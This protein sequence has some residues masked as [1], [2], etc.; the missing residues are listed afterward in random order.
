MRLRAVPGALLLISLIA[1]EMRVPLQAQ[2]QW[3]GQ[4]IAAVRLQPPEQ[5]LVPEDEGRA[6]ASVR[7]GTPLQLRNVSS[8]I[9]QLFL[10]GRFADIQ[11]DAQKQDDGILLTFLVQP[12]QFVRDVTVD[13]VEEPPSAGQLVNATKLQLGEL[14]EPTRV[15]QSVEGLMESLRANGFYLAQVVP[16]VAPRPFQQ[17]DLRFKVE[18]GG[19]A[20]YSSPI[21]RGSPNLPADEVARATRWR[22]FFRFLGYKDVTDS[23][24]GQGLDRVRRFYQKRDYLMARVTLEHMEHRPKSNDVV[25]TINVESG[26]K[27]IVRTRGAKISRGRLR[28]L[29]PIYQE[30]TVDRDLLVEGRREVTEYLQSRGYFDAQVDFDMTSSSPQETVIEY[31]L[32]PGERHK[33]VFIETN[34]NEYFSDE[35]L[36]ERMYVA[37]ASLLRFRHGR[38]SQDYLRRDVNSLRALYDA[39]GFRD[40]QVRTRVEDDYNGKANEVAVFFDINEGAQWRI[41]GLQI[42][43]V[44]DV[45]AADLRS[46]LQSTE[47]Q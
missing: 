3:E 39:N 25:P 44:D 27:V 29:V 10:T 12:A 17:V 2:T 19:R 8:A 7:P 37:T 33:L 41:E 13:G 31:S 21:I 15:R 11:V 18:T 20:S 5:F 4:R 43:G 40:V 6:L 35:T 9:E 46:M 34:G 1:L 22:N 38:F 14:F 24:T 47:G 42:S 28:E 16:E 30:L 45:T 36:R 26:P 23:R 32:F